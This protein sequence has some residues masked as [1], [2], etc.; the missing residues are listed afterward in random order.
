[1]EDDKISQDV[2]TGRLF[3]RLATNLLLY[4]PAFEDSSTQK[5]ATSIKGLEEEILRL[6]DEKET[7]FRKR[8]L[9][10]SGR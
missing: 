8:D 3:H 9:L 2:R 5:Y 1:L 7:I 10:F 4:R 6:Q